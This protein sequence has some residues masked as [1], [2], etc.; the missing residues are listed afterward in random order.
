MHKNELQSAL[1]YKEKDK[2]NKD[3]KYIKYIY[4]KEFIYLYISLK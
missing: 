3:I 2:D 1:R 4:R